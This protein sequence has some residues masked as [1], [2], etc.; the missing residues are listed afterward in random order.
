MKNEAKK[1]VSNPQ[2][3]EAAKLMMEAQRLLDRAVRLVEPKATTTDN[4]AGI[5][6]D[7]FDP[8]DERTRELDAL[9]A[10]IG[11][12]RATYFGSRYEKPF[13][14]KVNERLVKESSELIT[15]YGDI[16]QSHMAPSA[17]AGLKAAVEN[18]GGK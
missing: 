3:A 10:R 5:G 16:L 7:L 17:W 18:A 12:L 4:S 6:I 9:S 1:E 15:M 14:Q 13:Y 8:K 2:V 11:H